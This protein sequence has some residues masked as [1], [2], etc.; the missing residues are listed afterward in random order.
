MTTTTL[1]TQQIATRVIPI[2][3]A[4]ILEKKAVLRRETEK[5][6]AEHVA[7]LGDRAI[8]KCHPAKRRRRDMTFC[9]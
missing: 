1:N 6:V 2:M 8:K 7:K 9:R 5:L 3:Y 4:N